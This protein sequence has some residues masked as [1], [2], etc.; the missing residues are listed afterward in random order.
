[1]PGGFSTT[2]GT[3]VPGDVSGDIGAKQ[4]PSVP[5]HASGPV[6]QRTDCLFSRVRQPN[7]AQRRGWRPVSLGPSGGRLEV[8]ERL[9]VGLALELSE[10]LFSHLGIPAH[11]D[12]Y[13]P[14][15]KFRNRDHS[16]PK[17]FVRPLLVPAPANEEVDGTRNR[18]SPNISTSIHRPIKLG[19]PVLPPLKIGRVLLFIF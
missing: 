9:P 16:V 6:P 2:S 3:L 15:C 4:H 13:T 5:M 14:C 18:P 1:M 19:S 12:E 8:A 10:E 7:S 11:R 17:L